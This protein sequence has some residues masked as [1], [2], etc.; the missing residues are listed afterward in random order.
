MDINAE[1]H[2][3]RTLDA[4]M[5]VT[6]VSAWAQIKTNMLLDQIIFIHK[7]VKKRSYCDRPFPNPPP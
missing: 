1:F 7:T 5:V 3:A 2:T 6:L 4:H